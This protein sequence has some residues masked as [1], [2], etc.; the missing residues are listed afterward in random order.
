MRVEEVCQRRNNGR[1]E[2]RKQ[3]EIR[4]TD[5]QVRHLAQRLWRRIF[6]GQGY[7]IGSTSPITS[8]SAELIAA[9]D[10][11]SALV[12][13]TSGSSRRSLQMPEI[14][15]V[16]PIDILGALVRVTLTDFVVEPSIITSVDVADPSLTS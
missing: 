4:H 5:S 9:L 12:L 13:F 11:F 7:D 14:C 3:C 2:A 8:A 1:S 16:V 10:E 15:T 6:L